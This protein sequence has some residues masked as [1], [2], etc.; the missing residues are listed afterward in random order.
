MNNYL[1]TGLRARTTFIKK[2]IPYTKE[3]YFDF[4]LVIN[5]NKARNRSTSFV[6]GSFFPSSG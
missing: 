4:P 3:K 5:L 2:I 6:G 1:Q